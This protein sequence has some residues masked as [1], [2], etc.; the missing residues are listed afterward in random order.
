MGST[1]NRAEDVSGRSASDDA[2]TL[3]IDNA[4]LAD[5]RVVSIGIAHGRYRV[6]AD[7]SAGATTGLDATTTTRIDAGGRL[8]TESFVN[9]HMHLDKVYTL[10]LAGDGALHAY[11]AGTMGAAMRSIV[12]DASAV[13]KHYDRGWI[14]PNVRRA[15]DEAVF[16]GVLHVQ[17]FV[18][19]DTTAG[20]EGMESVLAVREEYRGLVD[21]QV[22]AFPQDGVLRDPGAAELCE[23]AMRLG[24]DVVGGIPWIEST[25]TDARAHVEWACALAQTAGTRVAMLVDDAGDPSLRTTE[26]LAEAMIRHSLQGRG[27]ACH[28]RAI[29]GYP[30]P[31]VI[32][33]V[34]L[35]RTA[36][37][38][39]VSDPHTGPLHLPVR[40]FLDD[41]LPVA[42]GQDDIEDAYYPF[43]RHNML[44]VA[45][46][47]AHIL[48]FLSGDDQLRLLDLITGRAAAVLGLRGHAIAEGNAANLCIHHSER[49][50][51]VLREHT[52]PRW[53]IRDGRVVAESEGHSRIHR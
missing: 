13:K 44:E 33:L 29:G 23:Q 8:V 7:V 53:V 34:E 49:L 22:V 10:P 12:E 52:R 37:L 42:L 20:L 3:I 27:V 1:G 41:D 31:S 11:T 35:A 32:R 48:Q 4:R 24:A 25:N 43:G 39:F 40:Q 17:A 18:D 21:V 28:A 16:N 30:M 51:D 50:V 38:A 6:V 9:G 36:R 2:S 47:A 26:M 15:L 46:L 19:V 45:F 5:G 14:M